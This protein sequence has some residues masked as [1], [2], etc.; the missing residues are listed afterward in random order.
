C[1]SWYEAYAFCIWDGGRLAT[2]AEWNYA[3]A[4]GDEQRVYPWSV[5]AT[6][7]TIDSTYAVY[8]VAPDYGIVGS[9]PNGNGRWG[10]ADLA[11][12]LWEWTRD[13]A[14]TPYASTSCTNCSNYVASNMHV[15]R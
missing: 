1:V 9:K 2:E 6:S 11:G 4:G 14:H 13:W 3:A 8:G 7:K 5:P 10:H 15:V 12:S